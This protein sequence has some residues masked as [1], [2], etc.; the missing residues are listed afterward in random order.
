MK[1]SKISW[2]MAVLTFDLKT[3]RTP[4]P[5]DD[6][7]DDDPKP[8]L[9]VETHWSSNSLESVHL[10]SFSRQW[11]LDFQIKCKVYC[12]LRRGL[13]TNSSVLV[14]SCSP[15]LKNLP[16]I[17]EKALFDNPAEQPASLTMTFCVFGSAD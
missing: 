6:D 2:Q 5:A 4:T 13:R 14:F 8:S 10:H 11:E 17:L 12:H 9:T 15:L 1:Y 7:D 16:H 3:R